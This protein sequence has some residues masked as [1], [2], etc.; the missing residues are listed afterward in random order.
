MT[1][2]RKVLTEYTLSNG[3]ILPAG[4]TV[5]VNSDAAH[6]NEKNYRNAQT[7]D[8]FRFY[9]EGD[10][11]GPHADENVKSYMVTTSSSYLP[12]GHGRH[13]W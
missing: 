9:H 4:S 3:T 5:S 10:G 2:Y 13:A 1:S 11:Y 12:F 7:F 8:G 6:F